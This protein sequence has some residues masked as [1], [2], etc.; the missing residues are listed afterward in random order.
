VTPIRRE[1]VGH[2]CVVLAACASPP[3]SQRMPVDVAPFA[4]LQAADFLGASAVLAA[5][6]AP[7]DDPKMRVGDAALFG[8]ELRREGSVDRLL[9][10]LEIEDLIRETHGFTVTTTSAPANGGPDVAAEAARRTYRAHPVKV[11]LRR[12]DAA[13][14][15]SR[16]SSATLYDEPMATGLW[17]FAQRDAPQRAVDMATALLL[18]LQRLAENDA[19]LKDLL[20]RVVDA[21]SVW[22]VATR[23]GIHVALEWVTDQFPPQAVAVELPSALGPEARSA[24]LAVKVNGDPALGVHVIMVKPA[25]ASRVCGGIVGAVAQH[26]RHPERLA[27]VRLLATRRGG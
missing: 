27:V 16:A 3:A 14:K 4:A 9:V 25:G 18:T 26:P 1:L 17:P 6:A 23:L 19:V 5:F 24:L 13:G 8:V 20:F 10:L 11:R 22:S 12:L 7:D 15:P 21:P 2:V